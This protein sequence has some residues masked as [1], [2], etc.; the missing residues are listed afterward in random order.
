[1]TSAGKLPR[2]RCRFV[3]GSFRFV[4]RSR[5]YNRLVA[6]FVSGGS[7]VLGGEGSTEAEASSIARTQRQLG[8]V[9]DELGK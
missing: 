6:G 3:P 8:G 4:L 1:M 5:L 9:L 7:R 2:F